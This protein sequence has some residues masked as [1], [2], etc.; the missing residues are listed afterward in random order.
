ML[1]HVAGEN[2]TELPHPLESCES[3]VC[4]EDQKTSRMMLPLKTTMGDQC[5]PPFLK[6][7][8][9]IQVMDI[10]KRKPTE[11]RIPIAT[12]TEFHIALKGAMPIGK[13]IANQIDLAIK[14]RTGNTIVHFLQ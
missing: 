10:T 5:L 7:D 9:E 14:S 4:I 1:Q 11:D 2:S 8:G 13:R 3:K 12:A 6:R